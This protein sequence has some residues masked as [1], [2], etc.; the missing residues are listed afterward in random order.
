M[1]DADDE[2]GVIPSATQRIR[3]SD[4][5]LRSLKFAHETS[6]K[7]ALSREWWAVVQSSAHESLRIDAQQSLL[8]ST[9]PLVRRPVTERGRAV[10]FAESVNAMLEVRDA[11][12]RAEDPREN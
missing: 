2:R 8:T 4:L 1:P 3:T 11:F 10:L 7:E 6:R 12:T 9:I 5:R